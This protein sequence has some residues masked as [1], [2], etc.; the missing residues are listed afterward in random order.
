MMRYLSLEFYKLRRRGVFLTSL[1]LCG[2]ECAWIAYSVQ[3]YIEKNGTALAWNSVFTNLMLIH[4]LFLPMAIA[5][6]SSRICDMEHKGDTWKLLGAAAEPMGKLY[7]AKFLCAFLIFTV[8]LAVELAVLLGFCVWSGFPVPIP[9]N[10]VLTTFAGTLLVSVFVLA[11][12][13]W[14]SMAIPNQLVALIVGMA[15]AF[16]GFVGSLFP[17][18]VRMFLPWCSYGELSSLMPVQS[19]PR[20]WD[21]IVVQPNLFPALFVFILGLILYFLGKRSMCRKEF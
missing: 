14:I 3:G 13:Q 12:Q 16:F 18:Q 20:E 6:L 15:G 1:L 10:L 21:Y 8:T 17:V 11:L 4:G 5:V 7:F 19:G 2:V 9:I